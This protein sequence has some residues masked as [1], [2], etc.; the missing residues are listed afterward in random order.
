MYYLFNFG[1]DKFSDMFGEVMI[2]NNLDMVIKL[3]LVIYV[4]VWKM[5]EIIK[6][7]CWFIDILILWLLEGIKI[8]ISLINF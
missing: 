3:G 1:K 5:L 4:I 7:W 8:L 6:S 2:S